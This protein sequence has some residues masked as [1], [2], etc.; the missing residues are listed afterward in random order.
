MLVLVAG[1]VPHAVLEAHHL[2]V[3]ALQLAGGAQRDQR[4]HRLVLHRMPQLAADAA[5]EVDQAVAR[6]GR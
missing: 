6:S 4:L 2:P 1:F 5:R 3:H